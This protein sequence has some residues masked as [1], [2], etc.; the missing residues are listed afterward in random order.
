MIKELFSRTKQFSIYCNSFNNLI[1]SSS[2]F[3][4]KIHFKMFALARNFTCFKTGLSEL[5][6]ALMSFAAA[7]TKI[8][9]SFYIFFLFSKV[10]ELTW[11][12]NDR[13]VNI[14]IG[15]SQPKCNFGIKL[16]ICEKY[17]CYMKI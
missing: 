3:K 13:R 2:V 16:S 11:N 8:K 10:M 17:V 4:P 1:A 7:C 5:L 15:S 6:G 14:Q 9:I 12:H